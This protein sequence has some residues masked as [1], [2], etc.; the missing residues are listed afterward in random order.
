MTNTSMVRITK[1]AIFPSFQNKI[2]R[3]TGEYQCISVEWEIYF[4]SSWNESGLHIM[5]YSI[6]YPSFVVNCCLSTSFFQFRSWKDNA[7]GSLAAQKSYYTIRRRRQTR[8][9]DDRGKFEKQDA[10]ASIHSTQTLR[11]L[12][13]QPWKFWRFFYYSKFPCFS[14]WRRKVTREVG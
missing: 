9:Y 14:K 10:S 2:T 11:S 1:A 5:E 6:P 3:E 12:P 13:S 7:A 4:S 8:S